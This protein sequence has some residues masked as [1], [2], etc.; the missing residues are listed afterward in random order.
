MEDRRFSKVSEVFGSLCSFLRRCIFG[1]LSVGPVP[2]HFAFIM[3]GNRR[4]AKK[5]KLE[6]GAGHRAGFSALMSILRYCYELGVRYVTIYAFSIENFKRRPEEV[7]NLMDLILEKIEGLLKEESIVNQHG[8][9]VYFIGN[10]KLL[11]EP[12]RMAAEKVMRVTSNN[13]R[14]VLLICIAYT[15]SDEIV[16]AVRGS[17]MGKWD[18]IQQSGFYKTY[19]GEIGEI[20]DPKKINGDQQ[21]CRNEAYESRVSNASMACNGSTTRGEGTR[22]QNSVVESA[23]LRSS[24]DDKWDEPQELKVDKNVLR[25]E[26]MQGSYSIIKQV[27][28]EKHMYMA[29]APDPDIVIRSSGETRLSNFLLWQTSN[30]LLYSPSA[31]WPEIGLRHLVWGVLEFQRNHSYLEKKKKQA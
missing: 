19:N 4:F 28:V 17:C 7:Q 30:C 20:D 23:L 9:R 25:N 8:I 26:I 3:D 24:E 16:N 1:I 31:L 21:Y 2:T 6:V 29:V 27:D 22:N 14:C 15:S 10:L 12:V 11:S 5:E 13:N 18:E